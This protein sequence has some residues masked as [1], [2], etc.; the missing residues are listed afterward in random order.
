MPVA[1][2]YSIYVRRDGVEIPFPYPE[3]M[4]PFNKWLEEGGDRDPYH[5]DQH[6]DLLSAFRAGLKRNKK[7]GGHL[8]D[9]FKLPGHPTFSIESKYYKEGMPAGKWVGDKYIPINR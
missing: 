9:T 1:K 5:P 4:K 8:P 3:E 2:P 7:K 6:Y